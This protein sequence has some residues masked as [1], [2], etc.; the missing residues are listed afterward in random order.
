MI[1]P[2]HA[3]AVAAGGVAAAR[4]GSKCA[5]TGSPLGSVWTVTLL[6]VS[7]LL[8]L[9]LWRCRGEKTPSR[10]LRG[11]GAITQES[12]SGGTACPAGTGGGAPSAL[13]ALHAG[14]GATTELGAA[15][16]KDGALARDF[17]GEL[18]GPV[19]DPNE[20]RPDPARLGDAGTDPAAAAEAETPAAAAA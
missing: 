6:L 19:S 8:P 3:T 13:K 1:L 14:T 11:G 2:V 15:T 20:P 10:A 17:D 9:A 7:E 16:A 12:G 5:W 4:A 18:R